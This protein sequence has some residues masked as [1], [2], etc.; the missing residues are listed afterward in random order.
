[1]YLGAN[2]LYGSAMCKTLQVSNFIW[3]DD[4]SKYNDLKNKKL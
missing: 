3:P 2:K 4:L 1:M